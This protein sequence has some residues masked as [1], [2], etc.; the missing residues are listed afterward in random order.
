MSVA[1]YMDVHVPRRKM[2][3]RNGTT[4]TYSRGRRSSAAC[5]F[6]LREGMRRLRQHKSFS[7]I[8]YAHQLRITIGR[9]VE[10][11]ELIA[12]ATSQEEWQGRIEYLPFE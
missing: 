12:R 8:V 7:G 1:L 3:R 6:L 2:Q 5:S 11:L 4:T 10:D 9:M